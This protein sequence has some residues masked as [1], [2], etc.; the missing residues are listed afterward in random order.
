MRLHVELEN[1]LARFFQADGALLFGSGMLANLGIISALVGPDDAVF[2]DQLNH[3][4]LID[5]CRL[6]RATV[7]VYRH[8]DIAHLRALLRAHPA[9][10]RLIVTDA[11]FSMDGDLA[12]LANIADLA[13]AHDAMV[14]VDEAHAVGV[15]GDGSGLCTALG[16]QSG[17]TVRMG[18]L[19]KALGSYGA[20]AVGDLEV[21][22]LLTNVSRSVVF[23]TALPPVVCA[24]ALASLQELRSGKRQAQL[25]GLQTR[26]MRRLQEAGLALHLPGPLRTLHAFP[27][28]VVPIIVGGNTEALRLA[29]RVLLRG[30]LT[31]G[32]RPP[33]VPK[34]TARL[35]ITLNAHHTHED[36]DGLCNVLRHEIPIRGAEL[37]PPP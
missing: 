11:V 6:S 30:Y 20:F 34:D 17:V 26:M 2:A 19:G 22:D 32:I 14:L 12:P 15:L 33:T 23:S 13:Q 16:V 37:W 36:V 8:G 21:V 35:R 9:P 24:A 27:T 29:E 10:R 1:D 18:T 5:G 4:S 3:A 25:N 7:H 31:V 28:P